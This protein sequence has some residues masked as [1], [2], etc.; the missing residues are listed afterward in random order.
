[1][2]L[3]G[4]D[5]DPSHALAVVEWEASA[6]KKPHLQILGFFLAQDLEVRFGARM[7]STPAASLS[8]AGQRGP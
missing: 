7:E 5:R 3:D 1:M 6:H 4:L 2:L 8:L